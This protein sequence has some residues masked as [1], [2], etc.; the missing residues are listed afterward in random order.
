[1]WYGWYNFWKNKYNATNAAATVT[2]LNA[3]IQRYFPNG[4][5]V[6]N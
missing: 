3:I 2:A 1:L 4:R 5:P 6:G